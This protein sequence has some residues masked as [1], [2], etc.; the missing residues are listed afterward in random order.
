MRRVAFEETL[1]RFVS[2]GRGLYWTEMETTDLFTFW[3]PGPD[4]RLKVTSPMLWGMV[5]GSNL[6]SHWRAEL[7]AAA[8]ISAPRL[9]ARRLVHVVARHGVTRGRTALRRASLL[10]EDR[11]ARER[12]KV[13]LKL[14]L[15]LSHSLQLPL[16][17][18]SIKLD[19][20]L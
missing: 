3:P 15:K 12:A 7:R 14:K 17:D 4:E 1:R 5:S 16:L 11:R 19:H 9:D 20:G 6:A 8:S 2:P 18:I 10:H 13:E